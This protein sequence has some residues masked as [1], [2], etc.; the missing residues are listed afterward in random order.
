M[1]EKILE[2]P[3]TVQNPVEQATTELKQRFPESLSDETRPGY[4]GLI[5]SP[6]K[7]REVATTL[8]DELGF[9]YLSS[10]TGVDLIDDNKMEVVYHIYSIEKGGGPIVLK[11]QVDRD[12]PVVPS[13]VPVWPG[14]DFQEREAWDLLGIRF[15]GH[16][17]LRRILTWDGF[18]GHPLRKDWKEPFY[19]ED[20]KPFGSR[21]PGGGVRRAEE[22][23]PY[24]KNV[25]YPPGWVPTGDEY[26]VETDLY[27]GLT[28]KKDETI[29]LKTEQVTVNI[30]PQH[31]STHGVFRMVV[32]LDGETIV[33][34]KPVMGYLHRNHEKIGERNTFIQNIPYT[35]RLDYICSMSNNLGY[36]LA[37]EKLL[38]SEVPERAEWLRILNVELTR[39]CNHLWA[40]GFLLNDLGALQTPMLYFYIE[41]ELIL[42]FFEALS[43]SR[44]MCN[45]MRFG[46]V[47]Y[48]L[49]DDVRGQPTLQFLDE[50]VNERLPRALEQGNELMTG[51]EIVQARS[52]GV[53]YL[54]PEDAIAYSTAGP[55]LRASGIPYD[56]RRAEPY[57]YYEHLDFDVAVRYNGDIYD[58]YLIRLDEMYQ[59]LRIIRQ[60]LPY[61]K[62]TEGAPII[63]GK[64][65]YA[66]R[67]PKGGEAYARVENPKGELGF[68]VT[69]KP[70]GSNPERYHVRAPSFIN[71]TALEK[72]TVGHKVADLVAILGSIDIVLGEVDR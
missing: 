61:L 66:L 71:L 37:V 3:D 14:A 25:Q 19:E 10:V 13:L 32:T 42:D 36:V 29:D 40:L 34:L 44:M 31:P 64:P 20:H 56:V 69:A 9:N 16:P 5:V 2:A 47:A 46:G 39:I 45:Y 18:H 49:P 59:S 6:D 11:A 27:T 58:R 57:S 62:E 24:G 48:D 15:D 23:N 22:L 52:I 63:S 50:L 28:I 30:G 1:S 60:V 70:K 53:G 33:A 68:Y 7:L 43:G 54:S 35:D 38:G 17:D 67:V 21:W 51:N 8:R 41:R 55:V 4:E 12:N 65:Q 26:E 72:M